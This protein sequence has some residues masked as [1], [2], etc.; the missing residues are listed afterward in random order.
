M[1][2]TIRNI[3]RANRPLSGHQINQEYSILVMIAE[4]SR[5]ITLVNSE[6]SERTTVIELSS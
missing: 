1:Q 2:Q 4:G 5:Y 3:L 6:K